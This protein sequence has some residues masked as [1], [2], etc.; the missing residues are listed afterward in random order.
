MSTA[1]TH[2]PIVHIVG[3]FPLPDAETVFRTLATATGPDFTPRAPARRR[4][5]RPQDLDP[6]SG[7]DALD[8]EPN[9]A[10]ERPRLMTAILL[11]DAAV[12]LVLGVRRPSNGIRPFRLL[13][14]RGIAAWNEKTPRRA[15]LN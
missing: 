14:K 11:Q 13:L 10:N 4:D 7:F 6:L 2:N 1:T 8:N 3:S 15:A 5:R 12:A 9:G